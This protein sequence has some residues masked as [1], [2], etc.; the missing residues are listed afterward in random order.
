MSQTHTVTFCRRRL[1]R[2]PSS[3][4]KDTGCRAPPLPPLPPRTP[5]CLPS[6]HG[7]PAWKS[8]AASRLPPSP[9]SVPLR[10]LPDGH[11]HQRRC[12]DFSPR[13]ALH[14]SSTPGH[15]AKPGLFGHRAYRSCSPGKREAFASRCNESVFLLLSLKENVYHQKTATILFRKHLDRNDRRLVDGDSGAGRGRTHLSPGA[16]GRVGAGSHV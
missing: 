7:S 9:H 16:P 8:E 5:H 13:C 11:V 2:P 10:E 4:P 6:G 14:A 3:L 12:E 15:P 1:G